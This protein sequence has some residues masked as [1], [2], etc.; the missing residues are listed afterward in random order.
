MARK[1]FTPEEKAYLLKL[2]RTSI[3][4]YLKN[5]R[6]METETD[7]LNLQ[8]KM[9]TFV[10]LTKY[11]NLRGCIGMLQALKPLYLDVRDNA[12]NAAIH[13]YRFEP[14][15]LSELNDIKIEI[16]VL[17]EP[18]EIKANTPEERLKALIPH[19]DGVILESGMARATYLPQV[20]E[21]LPN[22]EEFLGSLCMKAGIIG[23][24]WQDPKTKL[25][26]YYV[27]AFHEEE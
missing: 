18:K 27:T 20:W 7:N 21:Q 1:N 10:T 2:A 12:V 23:H 4:Y 17:T 16:S 25:Y 3:E 5:N 22:K 15:H 6:L 26:K 8:K 24:A 19:E 13:D 11:G 14:L 9:A